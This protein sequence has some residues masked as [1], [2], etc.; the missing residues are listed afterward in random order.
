MIKTVKITYKINFVSGTL[1][2]LYYENTTTVPVSCVS[3]EVAYF[4]K[5]IKEETVIK[6]VGGSSDYKIVSYEVLV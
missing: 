3:R 6:T 4:Q 1:K 2:G 5:A